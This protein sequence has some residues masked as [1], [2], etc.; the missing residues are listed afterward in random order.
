MSAKNNAAI[1]SAADMHVVGWPL[2]DAV[3][4][5]IDSIR[6]R[7]AI[8]LSEDKGGASTC[9]DVSSTGSGL[10]DGGSG[11]AKVYQ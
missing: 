11:I 5:R 10:R 9:N 3:V 2:A 4:A 8:L 6:R 1:K 7:V